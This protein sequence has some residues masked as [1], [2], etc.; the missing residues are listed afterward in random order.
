MSASEGI[1]AGEETAEPR[2]SPQ[3]TSS[4]GVFLQSKPDSLEGLLSEGSSELSEQVGSGERERGCR[5]L[6]VV[7]KVF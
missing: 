3:E 6:N 1:S 2:G 7:S 5:Y 4:A